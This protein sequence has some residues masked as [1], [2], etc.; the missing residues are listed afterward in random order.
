MNLLIKRCKNMHIQISLF[1]SP[2]EKLDIAIMYGRNGG[3][4]SS[5][6]KLNMYHYRV[7]FRGGGGEHSPPPWEF[8]SDSESIQVF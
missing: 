7:S 1:Y 3:E 4:L 5:S 8:C 6:K 2:K